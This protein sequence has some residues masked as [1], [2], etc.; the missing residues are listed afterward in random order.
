MKIQ[1]KTVILLFLMISTLLFLTSTGVLETSGQNPEPVIYITFLTPQTNPERMQW[2]DL[3]EQEIAKIGINVSYEELAWWSD[4]APRTWDYPYIY[5]DYIPTYNEGGFDV[6]F[7]G[8]PWELDWDPT[9]WYETSSRPPHGENYYQYFNTTYNELYNN[10][11]NEFNYTIRTPYAHQMQAILHE[12]LPAIGILYSGALYGFRNSL[13]GIDDILL[14]NV[15]H[16]TEAWDD[17]DD[18]KINI[19]IPFNLQGFHTFQADN[20][21]D[22]TWMRPVYG[23]LFQ[24]GQTHHKWEPV[25]AKN[26]TITPMAYHGEINITVFLDPNAKFSDG[27]YVLPEDVMYTYE[28]HMDTFVA[29]NYR[30]PITDWLGTTGNMHIKNNVPGG[31]INFIVE[32]T[33]QYPL[34]FLRFGI[35]DKS[36]VEPLV[37]TQGYSV[38]GDSP[39]TGN[40]GWSLVKSCG[41][42]KVYDGGT[43]SDGYDYVSSIVNLVPNAFWNNNTV[44]GGQQ[45]FLTNLNITFIGN[46]STA[47]AELLL[48]NID[49][50][51]YAYDLDPVIFEGHADIAGVVT[52]TPVHQELSINMKHPI[53]G[54]GELTPLGTAEAAKKI[55][56]AISHAIPRQ[57]IIDDIL[58]GTAF[59]GIISVPDCVIEF[60]DALQPYSYDISLALHLMEQAGYIHV[61]SE[62]NEFSI[63]L[64]VVFG[65][66]SIYSIRRI[67]K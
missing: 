17:S 67:K 14:Y 33:T 4:I 66:V 65:V 6:L 2:A 28:L 1:T 46:P 22:L 32:N 57:T 63:I 37:L 48:G 38:F 29:S 40:A 56:Q 7:I 39:G 44:S 21:I 58:N 49:I 47:F 31:Q 52:K 59:P 13:S 10:Y 8:W 53:L 41:P 35:I 54:T 3:I 62:Y 27:N 20:Y 26:Y 43:P 11:K 51:D 12:D 23:G 5:Y 24:R 42:F 18:H 60:N 25:I 30:E 16:R 9:G 61:I 15:E 45:P 34:S 36:E 50:M 19:G 55:R 64:I